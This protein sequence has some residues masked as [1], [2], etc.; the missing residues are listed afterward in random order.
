MSVDAA[1]NSILSFA[2]T[3]F[4]HY[5]FLVRDLDRA[6][7]FYDGVLGLVRKQR[8]NFASRGIWYDVA[9]LELHLIESSQVPDCHEG[10]PALEVTDLRAAVAACI[11]SGARLQQDVFLREH[12][13]SFSAFVRDPDDNLIELCSHG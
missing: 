13:G 10:H 12:D 6:A 2:V 1:A 9:G 7:A 5:T 11:A 4:H 3:G 8:P